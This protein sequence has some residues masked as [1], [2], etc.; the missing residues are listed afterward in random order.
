[1][2]CEHVSEKSDG[3][4]NRPHEMSNQFEEEHE[5]H[6]RYGGN[7]ADGAKKMLEV[8]DTVNLEAVELIDEKYRNGHGRGHIDV[9]CRRLE[10][11]DQA[12]EVTSQNIQK[13]RAE[14]RIKLFSVVVADVIFRSGKEEVG[15]DLHKILNSGGYQAQLA[16]HRE[17]GSD[18]QDHSKPGIGDIGFECI[19]SGD[20]A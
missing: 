17:S 1:M 3:E 7:G 9:A 11:G 16:S 2:F 6:K 18:K 4:S 13:D 20:C 10:A 14:Q 8:A 19:E 5:Y 12:K 15:E